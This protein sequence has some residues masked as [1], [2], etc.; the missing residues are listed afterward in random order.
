M[1]LLTRDQ[2]QMRLKRDVRVALD[3]MGGD[4][5]VEVTV[6]GALRALEA[7]ER[8][9]VVLA[10][11]EGQI[12]AA[13]HAEQPSDAVA[14]RLAVA[15]S[16]GVVGDHE[17]VLDVL[18]A[19]PNASIFTAMK[20]VA[21]G[22]ADAL[23]SVGPTSATF[24]AAQLGYGTLE[25]IERG[26]IGGFVSGTDS[27]TLLMDVGAMV[28]VQ[29]RH[30]IKMATLGT[31]TLHSLTGA[32]RPRVAVLNIGVESNKGN[33][34]TKEVV[35]LLADSQLNFIGSIEPYGLL[36]GEADL[37]MCDGF[38][39][40]MVLKLVE[41]LGELVSTWL[42][43]EGDGDQ[44]LLDLATRLYRALNSNRHYYGCTPILGVDGVATIGHGASTIPNITSAIRFT[45]RLV[46]FEIVNFQRRALARL[47]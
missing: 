12:K 25:G 44:R 8:L 47:L 18:N 38:V 36:S 15:G 41:G 32:E 28:D 39:G 45:A 29:P 20:R 21:D 22:E 6:P 46:E 7:D 23:L 42:R 2:D 31:A 33:Q 37:V 35:K 13:L 17:R 3:A 27:N 1:D 26:T 34:Q 16:E 4:R 24:V 14:A 10:G 9:S 40:N 43:R 11:D 30:F 5:G 19:K